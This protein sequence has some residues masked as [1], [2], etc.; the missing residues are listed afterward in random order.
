M[1]LHLLVSRSDEVIDDVGGR[2]VASGA[3][4]P[5]V[6]SQALDDAGWGVNATVAVATC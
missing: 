3:A 1:Q 6:A 4:E 2:A 5:L